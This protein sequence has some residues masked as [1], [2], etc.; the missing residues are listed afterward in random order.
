MNTSIVFICCSFLKSFFNLS[1][2][3]LENLSWVLHTFNQN[4]DE[5]KRIS[6]FITINSFIYSVQLVK[7]MDEFFQW[8]IDNTCQPI[9][10]F[11]KGQ[12]LNQQP[13]CWCNEDIHFALMASYLHFHRV[14]HGSSCGFCS[15]F[16]FLYNKIPPRFTFWKD[17]EGHILKCCTL[18]FAQIRLFLT[19]QGHL[20]PLPRPV[21]QEHLR[22]KGWEDTN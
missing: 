6:T 16:F 22:V 10:P 13:L 8:T 3:Y 19:P 12:F 1:S 15:S 7:T 21:R 11:I 9:Q 2:I 5:R 17:F 18:I 4:Q 20:F 14:A